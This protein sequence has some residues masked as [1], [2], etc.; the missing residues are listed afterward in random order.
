[1]PKN[2]RLLKANKT[3]VNQVQGRGSLKQPAQRRTELEQRHPVWRPMTIAQ[4]QDNATAEHPDRPLIITDTRTLTYADVQAQSRALASGMIA[5]GLKQGEHVALIM[6]NFPEFALVKLAIARAGATCIPVNF[7]LKAQELAYV[8][9]QSDT[10]M[11]ITMDHFSGLDYLAE[12]DSITDDVPDLRDVFVLSTGQGNGNNKG[13]ASLADLAALATPESDSELARREAAADGSSLSD[14]LYTSGTTGRSKGVM[15]THDMILRAAYSSVLTR[16][17]E[18]GRRIQFALPMYHV[19]GYVECFIG[20]MFVGGSIVPH[21]AFDPEEMFDWAE[22]FETNDIV[23]VPVMTQRLIDLARERG[24][25]APALHTVFNSGGVNHPGIWAEIR[26]VLKP[27]EI[28]TG[29]GMSETTASTV[30]TRVEDGDDCLANSNGR[31]KLAGIAGDPQVGGLVADYRVCDPHSGE[32]LA[33]GAEGELQARGPI[34]TRGYY[35]K[36]D[37]TAEAFTDDGWFR[38][39]DVGRVTAEGFLT[40]TGRIKETYRCGGEM[41][42]PREIEDL[43][44]NVPGIA[45]AL[46]VGIPDRKMGEVGCL[47]LVASGDT[48]PAGEELIAMCAQ[49][50]ARFK[51]PKHVL[52][53]DEADIPLTVTG[54]PQ[55]FKLAR[56]AETRITEMTQ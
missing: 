20:S 17:F 54:R 13:R 14:I 7:L 5:A 39:G 19:F 4:L 30:C 37:E 47:C 46:V 27:I 23:C 6:A 24:L 32:V 33:P 43:F 51:V 18:D 11:L 49:R 31:L 38:S 26:E 2:K 55:K 36:P 12:I 15:L 28:H 21:P 10:C 22:R 29:Y 9:D 41:V 8:L 3:R 44:N 1:M 25:N 34:V 53:L 40:L 48:P 45:Q 56:L 35:K 42:M 16:A 52:W 50:L